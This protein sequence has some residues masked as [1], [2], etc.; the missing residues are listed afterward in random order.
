MRFG[1]KAVVRIGIVAA[2]LFGF[3]CSYAVS[4]TILDDG[5]SRRIRRATEAK[6]NG[7]VDYLAGRIEKD[8]L[9]WLDKA[10]L[11]GFLLTGVGIGYFIYPEGA[12]ILYHYVYGDGSDF[13]ISSTYF[14]Q[15]R[16]LKEKIAKLG[17]GKHGPIGIHQ[18][19]DWRLSLAFNP[20]YLE[21]N[22]RRARIYHPRIEFAPLGG[23]RVP[24][25]VPLGKLRLRVYDNLV[26]ALGPKLFKAYA[27]WEIPP[28]R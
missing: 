8:R 18:R 5:I 17:R 27:E 26:S 9:S 14:R 25:I 12:A 6:L 4:V 28:I 3:V 10:V 21:I 2:V 20:F 22:E 13:E 24:T 11:H 15:N 16:Y 19:H 1:R 7:Y 23:K